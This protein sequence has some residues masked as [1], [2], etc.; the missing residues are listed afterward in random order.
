MGWLTE[1][2]NRD[3]LAVLMKIN[4]IPL[5]YRQYDSILNPNRAEGRE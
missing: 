1:K 5:K 4:V 3:K 2:Q